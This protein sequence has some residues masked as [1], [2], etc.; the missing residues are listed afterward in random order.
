MKVLIIV[1]KVLTNIIMKCAESNIVPY[2]GVMDPY[3][4]TILR[5]TL[6]RSY[7]YIENVIFCESLSNIEYWVNN[8]LLKF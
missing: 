4:S 8:L 6:E 3:Y 5:N 1:W 2:G 7:Y